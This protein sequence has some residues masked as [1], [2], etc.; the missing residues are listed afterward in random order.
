MNFKQPENVIA[1]QSNRPQDFFYVHWNI[2]RRCNYDC[3]YCPDSLHDFKSPHRSL[4]NLIEIAEKLKANIP[5]S[6]KI[7]IWFTGGEP[8]VNPNFLE[9]CKWLNN[10]G[11]FVVGLNTNGSRTKEYLLELMSYINIIQFSSHFEYVEE[12][13]FLP[14]M[15][16]ISNYVSDKHGKSMSLNLMMEPEHWDKAV[17]MVKYCIAHNIPYHMKRIRPKSVVHEG[18]NPYSPVYTEN[19]IKFLTD[20]EYRN[21]VLEEYDD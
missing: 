3:S 12:D 13:K 21:V 10:D 4:K 1:I 11:R 19:Q 14:S 20:N 17:R 8:T 6:K 7:R 18:K 15:K 5:S 2:G 16:A 9:F